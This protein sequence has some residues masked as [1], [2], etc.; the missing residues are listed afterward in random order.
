[1]KLSKNW[2]RRNLYP[3]FTPLEIKTGCPTSLRRVVILNGPRLSGGSEESRFLS[4]TGFTLIEVLVVVA[5]ISIL[6]G[7]VIPGLMKSQLKAN[8]TAVKSEIQ[9]IGA[10]LESYQT[11]FGDYPPSSLDNFGR[12]VV[13][14]ETNNGIESLLACL[15]SKN[16]GGPF[17]KEWSEERYVNL[18]NDEVRVNLT[19]W[20]FGDNRLREL[21]D[22]WGRPYIYFHSRD[23]GQSS[24]YT[25]EGEVIQ[26]VP[27][28]SERTSAYHNPVSY[29][30]WSVGPDG[31]NNNGAED[32]INN[33][34]K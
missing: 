30:L 14:D 12:D 23:Y 29:Q 17:L 5:I 26:C 9:Q 13:L 15:S 27:Q 22:K 20:W 4:L 25:I 16:Q 28:Q 3:G 24:Q 31:L 8:I 33:W 6:A 34:S 1:M 21:T 32:D 11:I 2:R 19:N 7:L 18:D 10:A